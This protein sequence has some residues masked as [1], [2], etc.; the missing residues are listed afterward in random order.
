MAAPGWL[1]ATV[2]QVLRWSG[3]TWV[4]PL[5]PTTWDFD[6]RSGG[7]FWGRLSHS[8]SL[9]RTSLD[10]KVSHREKNHRI[11]VLVET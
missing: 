5:Q 6:F 2:T 10:A 8:K 4:Q 9:G 3:M 7:D 11:K 1:V